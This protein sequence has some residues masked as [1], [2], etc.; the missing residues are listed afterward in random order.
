[1]SEGNM[2]Y[3]DG[4]EDLKP[5]NQEKVKRCIERGHV[6]DSDWKGVSQSISVIR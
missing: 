6:D 5:E 1:M 2:E 4:Y 3:V